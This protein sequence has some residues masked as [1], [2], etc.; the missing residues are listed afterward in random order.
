MFKVELN[1]YIGEQKESVVDFD[2]QAVKELWLR[3]LTDELRKKKK[4]LVEISEAK[5]AAAVAYDRFIS[6][7]KFATVER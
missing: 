5:D 2:E 7:V 4:N 1:Y 6:M 3:Y